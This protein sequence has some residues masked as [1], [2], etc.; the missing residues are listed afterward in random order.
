MS[1]NSKIALITGASSGIGQAT[2]HIF[3]K[4]GYNLFL[5]AR[6]AERLAELKSE[7]EQKYSINVYCV[8][9]DLRDRKALETAWQTVA[10]EWKKIDV[11]VNNAG[12]SLGLDPFFEGNVE[13]LKSIV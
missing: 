12:L 13:S 4:H 11:L 3:A 5:I 9:L 10:S 1:T 8:T 2:A 7:L 6:R